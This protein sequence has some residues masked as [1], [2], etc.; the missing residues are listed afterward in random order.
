MQQPP[1][2]HYGVE[3]QPSPEGTEHGGSHRAPGFFPDEHHG[4]APTAALVT[5]QT[6]DHV[7]AGDPYFQGAVLSDPSVSSRTAST[8]SGC[9]NTSI[10]YRYIVY[11]PFVS[12]VFTCRAF[13]YSAPRVWNCLG[14]STRLANTFSTGS[15]RC[16]LPTICVHRL[17]LSGVLLLCT[18]SLELSRDIHKIGE[19]FQYG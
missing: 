17:H 11:R 13:Y 7:Q 16:C 6:T 8:P 4:S 10:Y 9:Q 5:D 3:P 14:T 12:T 19:H 15:C 2:C 1:V 18:S